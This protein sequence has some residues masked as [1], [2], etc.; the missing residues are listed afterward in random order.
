MQPSTQSFAPRQFAG[1]RVS[2]PSGDGQPVAQGLSTPHPQQL[3]QPQSVQRSATSH[4]PA[5][6]TFAQMQA[7]GQAR[8][9]PP[10]ASSA[11]GGY[12]NASGDRAGPDY[13]NTV[14]PTD[15]PGD[16]QGKLDRNAQQQGM[17]Q[18][19]VTHAWVDPSSPEYQWHTGAIPTGPTVYQGS[20]DANGH[21]TTTQTMVNGVGTGQVPDN[22]YFS[23]GGS[24][25]PPRIPTARVVNVPVWPRRVVRIGTGDPAGALGPFAL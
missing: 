10:A 17:V 5:P 24:L 4:P 2:S 16:V 19:P 23:P 20:Y 21:P 7:T 8:P 13:A 3:S 14:Q 18:D 1:R 25:P 11:P 12:V 9:N 22:S 15:S 6:Q